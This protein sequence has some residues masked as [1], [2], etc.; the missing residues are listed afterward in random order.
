M[1]VT[2]THLVGWTHSP[3]DGGVPQRAFAEL[4]KIAIPVVKDYHSDI[5]HDAVWLHDNVTD[6]ST[7]TFVYVVRENGTHLTL[8]ASWSRAV[9]ESF[10]NDRGAR[11]FSGAIVCDERGAWTL[12]L[13]E[14]VKS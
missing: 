14:R 12:A 3:I 9:V 6:D 5:F 4:L 7:L 10:Q 11:V 1:S 8:D 2:L 13:S